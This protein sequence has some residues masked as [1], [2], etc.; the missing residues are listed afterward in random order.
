[1]DI[2]VR[3]SVT[4]VETHF[5]DTGQIA[6]PPLTKIAEI[7][8]VE[9]PYAGRY[10]ADLALMIDASP[11]LGR[12]MAQRL[13]RALDGA[14]VQGYGKA[15]LV[16]IE[17]EKE[18]AAA[19][20]TTAFATPFRDAIGGDAWISSVTK[21]CVPGSM[22]DVPMNS[23]EDVY[24]RSHYDTMS[25][26]LPDAPLPREIALIF[27]VATRGRLNARV[28]GLSFDEAKARRLRGGALAPVK[29]DA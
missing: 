11:R 24:V 29:I 2:R 10:V 20:L 1:M 6:E 21:V 9:N 26:T 17:G 8:V 27:C 28:G 19:L 14:E 15:G 12:F 18:H 7:L 23:T 5:E 4:I 3:R 22:V 25:L 13:T 16:G